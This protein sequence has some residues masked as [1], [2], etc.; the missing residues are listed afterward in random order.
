MNFNN[1]KRTG[2]G[3]LGDSIRGFFAEPTKYGDPLDHNALQKSIDTTNIEFVDIGNGEILTYRDYN[4]FNTEHVLIILPAYAADDTYAAGML[5][6]EDFKDHRMIFVNPRG[7]GMSTHNTSI[8]SHEEF[9]NDI[10]LLIDKIDG[11]QHRPIMIMGFSTGAATAA[12]FAL[13]FPN[14]TKACFMVSGV[15]LDGLRIRV[16]FEPNTGEPIDRMVKEREDL[17]NYVRG[18]EYHNL[19]SKNSESCYQCYTVSFLPGTAPS[20]D[21][22]AWKKRIHPGAYNHVSR[23]EAHVANC[24]FNITP[25]QTPF[26]KP[27]F[28]LQDLKCPIIVL[29]G[30]KDFM[31]ST[32]QMRSVCQLAIAENWVP[33]GLLTYVEFSGGHHPLFECPEEFGQL[34]RA[35]LKSKVLNNVII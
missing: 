23:L 34:Y 1:F 16:T 25:I 14:K 31:T 27:S 6:L 30:K 10:K 29:H 18:L 21:S 3:G 7:Y 4:T 32:T 12:Q 26:T 11:L 28:V 33:D 24:E 8:Y 13:Q 22:K 17:E 5:A 35:T 2:G 19:F 9:A 20:I 15:P